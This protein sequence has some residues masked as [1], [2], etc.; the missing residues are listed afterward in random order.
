VTV[1]GLW[2]SSLSVLLVSAPAWPEPARQSDLSTSDNR[3][4]TVQL[5]EEE[6]GKCRVVV[7]QAEQPMWTLDK[8]L[9]G[10]NDKY[11]VSNS[12]DRV[13]VLYTLPEQLRRKKG[14]VLGDVVVATLVTRAG[15]R[16]KTKL[17][18]DFVP[19]YQY[20]RLRRLGPRF[21]WL[22][23]LSGMP[24][25]PPHIKEGGQVELETV[26]LKTFHLDFF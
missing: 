26:E 23:G 2:A 20:G 1:R 19:K 18:K 11:F 16:L 25:V 12:G 10:A 21:A 5:M 3:T 4:Y 13:W 15:E 17:L 9:G 6:G 22:G 7:N 24:G 14:D 8:C